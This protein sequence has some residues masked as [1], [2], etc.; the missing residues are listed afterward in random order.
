MVET[1]EKFGKSG[2]VWDFTAP[3]VIRA[4]SKRD[5]ISVIWRGAVILLWNA[6]CL[7]WRKNLSL[8][9][10]TSKALSCLEQRKSLHLLKLLQ[11]ISKFRPSEKLMSFPV[12][13]KENARCSK[14]EMHLF[15]SRS[16]AN[17][18]S[19]QSM[20][21]RSVTTY[22]QFVAYLGTLAFARKVRSWC[23]PESEW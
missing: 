20:G 15:E 19:L 12:A 17:Y 9:R 4:C 6:R 11:M 3:H 5:S 7:R 21:G 14:T 2:Q 13:F 1:N 22:V 23:D 16:W 10:A 8:F 18:V